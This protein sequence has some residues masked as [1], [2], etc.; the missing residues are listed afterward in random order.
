MNA[1]F[2]QRHVLGDDRLVDV[3][4]RDLQQDPMGTLAS[5]YRHLGLSRFDQA[6]PRFLAYLE[7]QR[8]YKKNRLELDDGERRHVGE[9]WARIFGRLGYQVS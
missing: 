9:R 3:A 7:S 5:I 8:N 2:D 4:F 6:A 1:F